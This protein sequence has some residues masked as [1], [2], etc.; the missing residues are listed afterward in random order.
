VTVN[1]YTAVP[2]WSIEPVNVSVV[3]VAV[4][5]GVVTVEALEDDP[6]PVRQKMDTI[7]NARPHGRM[8]PAVN[9]M[10]LS[11]YSGPVFPMA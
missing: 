9:F 2:F 6:H 3:S 11:S 8:K 4:V 5:V 1:G 10:N 7:E